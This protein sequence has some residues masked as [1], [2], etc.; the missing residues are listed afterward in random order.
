MRHF[1]EVFANQYT[2]D[3]HGA[4]IVDKEH[5]V[6]VIHVLSH[7]DG[8][9]FL[10]DI[11]AIDYLHVKTQP[12]RFGVVYLLRDEHFKNLITLKTYIDSSLT[13]HSIT[14]LFASANWA[15]RE[16]DRKSVV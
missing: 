14:S 16:I 13:T 4:Y 6:N 1:K 3:A 15:E 11:T 9:S 2:L 10:V 8:Y 12:E 7:D 5:I